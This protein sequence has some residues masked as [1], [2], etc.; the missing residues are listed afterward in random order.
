MEEFQREMKKLA[1]KLMW[2]ILEPLGVTAED[3][4]WAG[5]AG[6]FLDSCACLQ[7]NSYPPCPSP[8]RVMGLPEHTDST[9]FTI[10]HQTNASHGLQVY[11]E[12]PPIWVNAPPLAGTLIIN[13][14]DLLHVLSNGRFRPP[15]HRA[16][17]SGAS[18]RVSIVYLWGPPPDARVSPLVKFVGAN[19]EATYRSVS[20]LEYLGMKAAHFN[21]A[22]SFLRLLHPREEKQNANRL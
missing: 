13:V 20:Y 6:D 5:P 3:I 22:L 15:L 12:D 17:V 2:L 1:Q 19:A 10:L 9:L 18:H 21:K 7:L 14:G 4:K 8:D 16:L 11:R